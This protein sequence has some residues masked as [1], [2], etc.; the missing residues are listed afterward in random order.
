MS[1]T[2]IAFSARRT[3]F[4]FNKFPL[5]AMLPADALPFRVLD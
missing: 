1:D 4:K 5:Q 2:P 3:L